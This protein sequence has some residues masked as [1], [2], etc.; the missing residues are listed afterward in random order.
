ML[1]LATADAR[2]KGVGGSIAIVD[3]GGHLIA[4]ARLD[5]TFP[6]SAR[7]SVGKARTAAMFR[8]PTSDFEKIVN[9]GRF[10]MTALEDFTPLQG[11]VPLLVDNQIVGAIGVSGTASAAQ[12]EEVALAGAKALQSSM[13]MDTTKLLVQ[14]TQPVAAEEM[15][16]QQPIAMT[17]EGN[18]TANILVNTDREGL[19]VQGYDVVSYFTNGRPEKGLMEFRSGWDGATYYF[20]SEEHKTMFELDPVKYVP[21]FG[22]YCGYAASINRLSPIS[23]DYWQIIDGRLI[24]QHNQRALD[25]WKENQGANVQKADANWPQLV[26]R[27][28]VKPGQKKL[29]NTDKDGVAI[30]GYDPVAYFTEQKPVMGIPAHEAV[31]NG[32]KYRFASKEHRE[33][34]EKDPAHYV[35]AYGGYCGYAASINKVSIINPIYWQIVDDRLVLQHT[36][37]A[38]DLFNKDLPQNVSRA[39]ANWN[40]LVE[41][42]GTKSGKRKTRGFFSFAWLGL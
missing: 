2:A 5:N 30:L 42:N 34:F 41:R 26:E 28:G 32:A 9:S 38:F 25:L 13:E 3:D 36:Q 24:L 10:T 11:G 15:S 7:V 21:A 40:G 1:D 8:K 16:H 39:D 35:P 23:P 29:I 12:D 14:A 6:A 27:N 20:T 33:I 37:G 31:Y 22:G 4:L 17:T 19:A 18:N